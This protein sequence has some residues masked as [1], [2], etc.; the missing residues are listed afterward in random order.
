MERERK[1]ILDFCYVISNNGSI[2]LTQWLSE[3]N[4]QQEDC[5]LVN[6]DHFRNVYLLYH[7]KRPLAV[8]T[9]FKGIVSGPEADDVLLSS[10]PKGIEPLVTMTFNKDSY[11]VYCREY[12]EYKDWEEKRNQVRYEGTL[13]HG[14]SYDAKKYDA[15]ISPFKYGRRN[16]FI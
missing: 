9:R 12:R 4:L 8:T 13:S 14:K 1:S 15:Y 2:P 16:C 10:V 11:S 7:Q 6:V 3:N 5:G